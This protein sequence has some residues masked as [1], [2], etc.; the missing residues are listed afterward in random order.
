MFR[1]KDSKSII[2][3]SGNDDV[4]RLDNSDI[5]YY[6]YAKNIISNFEFMKKEISDLELIRKILENINFTELW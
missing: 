4:D 6:L 1:T 2:D 3:C 5:N